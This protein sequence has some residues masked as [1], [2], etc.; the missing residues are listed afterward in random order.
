MNWGKQLPPVHGSRLCFFLAQTNYK[1][2][3][4]GKKVITTFHFPFSI[5]NFNE[6]SSYIIY[7]SAG[8]L[9]YADGGSRGVYAIG[10]W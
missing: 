3:T 8:A 5:F 9:P 1:Q 2:Y 6:I 7:T 4:N 10:Q